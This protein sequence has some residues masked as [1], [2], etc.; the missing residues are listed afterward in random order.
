[1]M[2]VESVIG[3]ECLELRTAW[4][5]AGCRPPYRGWDAPRLSGRPA[6]ALASICL[7]VALGGCSIPIGSLFEKNKHDDLEMT[8]SV[9]P[10]ANA[11]AAMQSETPG[12]P[13]ADLAYVKAAA[14]EVLARGGKD[15]SQN[16]E[17]PATGARGAVTPLT[18][19]YKE[20]GYAC[21]DFLLSHVQGKVETWLQGDACKY[22]DR[23]EVRSLRSWKR[24]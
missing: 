14:S 17:N 13:E 4:F 11:M 8:G 3:R 9:N 21:R 15:V 19:P 2:V 22:A 1:L 6:G 5:S 20:N 7:A 18:S 23:W 16:W 10:A 24:S 12:L